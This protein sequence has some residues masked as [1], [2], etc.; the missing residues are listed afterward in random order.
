MKA[1]PS[2]RSWVRGPSVKRPVPATRRSRLAGMFLLVIVL[3]GAG[4]GVTTYWDHVQ[5]YVRFDIPW[6]RTGTEGVAAAPNITEPVPLVRPSDIAFA[7]AR[8]LQADGRLRDALRTLESIPRTDVLWPQS[9]RL[10]AE[11]QQILLKGPPA[12]PSQP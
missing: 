5:R 11:I 1:E 6:L 3:A 7:R 4:G 2:A 8:Q 9:E 10:R 12:P